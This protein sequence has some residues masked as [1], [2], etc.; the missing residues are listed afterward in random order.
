MFFPFFLMID[1]YLLIPDV[2]EQVFN[3]TAE[4]AMPTGT[5]IN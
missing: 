4:F 2:T 3:S 1:L 5:A